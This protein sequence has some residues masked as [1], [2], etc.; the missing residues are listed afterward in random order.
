MITLI[1]LIINGIA[2]GFLYGVLALGL[3]LVYKCTKV[4]NF[5]YGPMMLMGALMCWWLLSQAWLP[6][7]AV[8]LLLVVYAIVLGTTIE[9]L[10]LRR[11][12]TQP[13]F[14]LIMMTIA[15]GV[16]VNGV[17]L[18]VWGGLPRSLS[19]FQFLPSVTLLGIG[20]SDRH[21][22]AL[23][24]GISLIVLLAM[25]FKWSRLG[26]DMKSVAED[27]LVAQSLGVSNTRVFAVT[28]V[29]AAMLATIVGF[30]LGSIWGIQPEMAKY[31][32]MGFA[33][34]LLGG[35][36]S[37]PGAIVAG[38]LVGVLQNLAAFYLNPVVG[39][40]IQEVFAYVVLMLV[41]L[42]RPHG[43]FGLKRIER[44]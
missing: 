3:V 5:A 27:P 7:W 32:I 43:L 16:V 11:L 36:E 1:Q 6:V 35:L 22:L 26:L 14:T 12:V 34:A 9:R 21:V 4:L 15:I 8:P 18:L 28:W 44:V 2:L 41:L 23:V 37:I 17:T 24:A 10:A 25:F 20:L 42:L 19:G 29:L 13:L 38:V 31:G 40:G 33:V 30:L 39:G